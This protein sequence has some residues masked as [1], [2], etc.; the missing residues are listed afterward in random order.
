MDIRICSIFLDPTVVEG[1][2]V[3]YGLCQ[4]VVSRRGCEVT[5]SDKVSM[6]VAESDPCSVFVYLDLKF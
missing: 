3:G 4:A 6:M 5:C 1:S 2:L